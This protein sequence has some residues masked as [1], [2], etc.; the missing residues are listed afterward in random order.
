MERQLANGKEDE[1]EAVFCCM[2]PAPPC[3]IGSGL[4]VATVSAEKSGVPNDASWPPPPPPPPL[5]T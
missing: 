3:M 2:P 4:G 1:D 5:P